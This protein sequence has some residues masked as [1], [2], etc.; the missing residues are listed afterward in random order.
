MKLGVSQ[1]FNGNINPWN[2]KNP[3][4]VKP[5]QAFFAAG[6]GARREV[7]AVA[8]ASLALR[9]TR[10]TDFLC[11]LLTRFAFLFIE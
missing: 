9:F 4:R 10:S 6:F 5:T 8:I 11:F 1:Y 7:F 3:I 2:L